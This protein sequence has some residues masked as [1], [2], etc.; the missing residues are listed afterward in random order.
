MFDFLGD[1]AK[2]IG[3][4]VGTAT[5]LVIGIPLKVIAETL[6]FTTKMVKE[7]MDAGC[8]TYE[9]IKDFWDGRY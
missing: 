8:E 2:G 4:I 5:G 6:G 1:M 7:A 9:E 3:K